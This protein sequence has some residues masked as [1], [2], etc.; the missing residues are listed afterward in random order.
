MDMLNVAAV[1]YQVVLT[2]IDKIKQPKR[3]AILQACAD[4]LKTQAAAF[5]L[6]LATSSE[7]NIGIEQLRAAIAIVM[8]HNI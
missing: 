6:M 2:K 1:S 3:D 8:K 7:K 4:V 5:P